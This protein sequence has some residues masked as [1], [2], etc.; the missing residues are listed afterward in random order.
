MQV[1]IPEA[2]W[3]SLACFGIDQLLFA[4]VVRQFMG[5]SWVID[6]QVV[7]TSSALAH[8]CASVTDFRLHITQ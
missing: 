7:S 2:C 4:S 5:Q 1:L 3:F 8:E 6:M